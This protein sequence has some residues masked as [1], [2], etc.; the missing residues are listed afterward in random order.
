MSIGR[1]PRASRRRVVDGAGYRRA[2]FEGNIDRHFVEQPLR[3]AG[4]GQNGARAVHHRAIERGVG[5]I[6]DER[7]DE[8]HLSE[9]TRGKRQG[10]AYRRADRQRQVGAGARA[11]AKNRRRRHQCRF[12]AGLSRPAR[13]HGA[14]DAGRGGAGAAPALRP[15]R[16]RREFLRRQLGG[17]C[18]K[19]AGGSAR[20]KSP[21]DFCRRLRS[22]FQGADAGAVGGAADPRRD[23]RQRARAAGT[24]RRRGAACRTGAARSG[25]R[26]TPETAR[27]HPHR[28]RAG[29]GR[30]DRRAR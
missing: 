10:G 21:A 7:G 22:V 5:G 8:R 24:R 2:A 23:T 17:R 19:G 29:S 30:G 12:H 26:R 20:A 1:S 4:R 16:R 13:H 18:C 14:A 3:R 15:C 28:P 27:S 9:F 6:A 11:G 25:I